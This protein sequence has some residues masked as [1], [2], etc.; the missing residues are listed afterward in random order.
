[1]QTPTRLLEPRHLSAFQCLGGDCEDTCCDG[2]AITV[3]KP[4]YERYQQCPDPAW[5]ASFDKLVTIQATG[6]TDHNYARI[7]LSSSTCPFLAEG[8]CS[9]HK[10]LG[11]SYLPVTCARFPR[12]WNVVDGVLEKSLDLGCPEAARVALLD[13]ES[14]TFQ[15]ADWDPREFSTLRVSAIDSSRGAGLEKPYRHFAVVRAFVV[16]LLQNRAHPL[17]KRLAILGLFCDKLQEMAAGGDEQGVPQMIQAYEEAV[18]AGL[19]DETLSQLP[20]RTALQLETVVELIVARITSDFTNRQFLAS[21][22]EFM[23]GL[24][25]GADSSMEQIDSRY[26]EAY[27]QYCAPFLNRHEHILEHYLVNYVW[28]GLFPF[29]PQE[30]TYALRDPNRQRSIHAE[31]QL[32]AVYF[33]MIQALLTGLAGFHKEFFGAQHVIQV[34]YTVTRTFEHSVAFPQR[35]MQT[36]GEKGLD[37]PAGVAVLLKF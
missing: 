35:V 21:Y 20:A 1:M 2:W 30:N 34:I 19:F 3:D 17:W 27:A 4:A 16:K 24:G 37:N 32:M 8:W 36:L 23:D 25:W 31:F 6:A 14:M 33:S 7:A 13:P 28:R 11:E 29:G 5:R 26:R 22:K 18:S 12:V 10:Q 9:I 15:Q